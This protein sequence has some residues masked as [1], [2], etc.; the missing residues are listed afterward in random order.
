MEST[1]EGIIAPSIR[2]LGEMAGLLYDRRFAARAGKRTPLYYMHRAI[3]R[4]GWL[5]Y[6]ITVIPPLMLGSEYNKTAGHYHSHARRGLSYPEVYEILHGKATYILQKKKKGGKKAK[7]EL[8]DVIL[9]DAKEGDKILMPPN[10]G[11][12]TVNRS[13][14]TLIMAN[15]VSDRCVSDY[16]EYGALKGAAYYITKHGFVRNPSYKKV[17]PIRRQKPASPLPR[18]LSL[19]ELLENSSRSL[20]FIEDPRLL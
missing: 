6:D 20:K 14:A 11:H 8:D 19:F 4:R 18:A 13:P 10:Y 3:A 9:I 12:V 17:P 2:R 1:R 7:G 5:R 15:I 16:S